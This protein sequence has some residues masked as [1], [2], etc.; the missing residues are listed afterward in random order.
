LPFGQIVH[1]VHDIAARLLVESG[2]RLVGQNDPRSTDESAR[3]R[4]PLLLSARELFGV[5]T[6]T[7]AEA[8][9]LNVSV[10]VYES[11]A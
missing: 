10:R 1:Q 4:D 9:G 7:L 6:D 8:D 3:D 11:R 2:R 5:V